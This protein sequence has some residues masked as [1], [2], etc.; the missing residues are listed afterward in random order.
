M[1]GTQEPEKALIDQFTSLHTMVRTLTPQAASSK[2]AQIRHQ[3]LK[4]LL[5]RLVVPAS[6]FA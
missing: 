2:L 4:E 3:Q 5:T 6:P 1:L